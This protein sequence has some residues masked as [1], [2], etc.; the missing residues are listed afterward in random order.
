M[1]QKKKQAM[2]NRSPFIPSFRAWQ[3]L[4]VEHAGEEGDA[5]VVIVQKALALA[6]LHNQVVVVTNYMDIFILLIHHASFSSKVYSK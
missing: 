6:H 4:D 3:R 2:P 1:V 5:D